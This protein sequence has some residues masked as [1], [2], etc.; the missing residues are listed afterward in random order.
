MASGGK[1]SI[2]VMRDDADVRRM[3]LSPFWIKAAVW[4]VVLLAVVAAGSAV[5]A[6]YYQGLV[7]T[8]EKVAQNA[9]RQAKQAQDRLIRLDEIETIL[10]S[11]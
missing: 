1:I 7:G 9:E 3:R 10:R 5:G 11:K 4:G 2:L 8:S 6:Y